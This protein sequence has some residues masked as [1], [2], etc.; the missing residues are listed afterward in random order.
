MIRCF[1]VALEELSRLNSFTL[2][3]P[4]PLD[5]NPPSFTHYFPPPTLYN[6]N[7]CFSPKFL[8]LDFQLSSFQTANTF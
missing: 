1:G 5:L 2:T 4:S 7:Q 8:P 3:K 6:Q